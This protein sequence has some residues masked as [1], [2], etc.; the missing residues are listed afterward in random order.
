MK[1]VIE[2]VNEIIIEAGQ[3]AL[4][5]EP[6][7]TEVKS[8]SSI[9]SEVDRN[10]ER[11]IT[12][13]LKSLSLEAKVIGEEETEASEDRGALL[14]QL[15][16]EEFLWCVDPIDGT[17][18]YLEGSPDWAV[19][20][21]LL[22]NGVPLIGSVYIPDIDELYYTDGDASYRVKWA[23]HDPYEPKR[24]IETVNGIA[25]FTANPRKMEKHG[26]KEKRRKVIDSTVINLL[27]SAI[28][29][30]KS[31]VT[32]G[33]LWDFCASLAI[34]KPLGLIMIDIVTGEEINKFTPESFKNEGQEYWK[35]KNDCLACNRDFVKEYL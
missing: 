28:G 30:A 31:T 23:F 8:D 15:T 27:Y 10:T 26:G 1:S 24:L 14:N 35:L 20:I 18:N 5:Q 12:S 29:K 32:S 11:M 21:G 22:Q 25:P 13:A 33:H 2:Q 3:Y 34:G 4:N 16:S 17:K 19:S 6:S 7:N 9:V